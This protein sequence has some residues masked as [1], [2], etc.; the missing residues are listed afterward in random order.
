MIEDDLDYHVFAEVKSNLT[1]ETIQALCSAG[2]RELQPGIESL[3]DHLLELMGKGNTAVNHVALLRQCRRYG[4][5]PHWNML[6][7][8]PGVTKED[9]LELLSLIP[10]LVHLP[11]PGGCGKIMFQRFSRYTM[12][13]EEY[14]LKLIPWK[15]TEY[16]FGDDPERIR[17]MTFHFDLADC[18]FAK[19]FEENLD[20]YRRLI[21]ACEEWQRLS[22]SKHVPVLLCRYG[23]DVVM[24]TDRRPLAASEAQL[25]SGIHNDL[26]CLLEAPVTESRLQSE[27]KERYEPAMIHE[28]LQE[29]EELSLAVHLSGKW[30]GAS[31]SGFRMIFS[32][33]RTMMIQ[34]GTS[35]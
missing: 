6:F 3:N 23:K 26:Y 11:A 7:G 30:F 27:L 25:L 22:R 33:V 18:G 1:D 9:Y 19:V 28:A 31:T 20:L 12:Y 14:D 10:K 21:D 5:D 16:L 34:L 35:N 2:I 8:I 29:L 17:E 15:G 4:A 13:P 24:I 32:A